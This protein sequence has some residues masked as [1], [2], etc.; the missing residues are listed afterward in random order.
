MTH[1]TD[2]QW[3]DASFMADAMTAPT[4]TDEE[5]DAI[6]DSVQ[7]SIGMPVLSG[8]EYERAMQQRG[9]AEAKRIARQRA[10]VRAA[11]AAGVA[12][13]S[14][15]A[16]ALRSVARRDRGYAAG[17]YS[18]TCGACKKESIGDKRCARCADCADAAI[19]AARAATKD[20]P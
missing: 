1:R 19:D 17:W 6:S 15:E 4:L 3:Q 12:A 2:E 7:I 5:C 8:G 9:Y 13:A 10:V 18:F 11:Y 14:A 20:K 16:D